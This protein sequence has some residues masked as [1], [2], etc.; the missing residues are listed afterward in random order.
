MQIA[1][2][3]IATLCVV[4]FTTTVRIHWQLSQ[5]AFHSVT[6]MSVVLLQT[7]TCVQAHFN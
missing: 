3:M 7:Q 5:A 1:L 4:P 6:L 2:F